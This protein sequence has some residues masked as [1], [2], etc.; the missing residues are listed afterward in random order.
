MGSET[1]G[2]SRLWVEQGKEGQRRS[3]VVGGKKRLK[4]IKWAFMHLTID[5][6]KRR[7]GEKKMVRKKDTK[8]E[9][10]TYRGPSIR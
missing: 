7:G 10:L 9:K 4:T 3:N 2:E 6:K 8:R 1:G 5:Q